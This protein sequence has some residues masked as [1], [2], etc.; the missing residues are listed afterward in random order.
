MSNLK[1]VPHKRRVMV[2]NDGVVVHRNGDGS[3]C[4]NDKYLIDPSGVFVTPHEI[5]TRYR[6]KEEKATDAETMRLL[7]KLFVESSWAMEKT[8][9]AFDKM[10]GAAREFVGL[11]LNYLEWAQDGDEDLWAA[12]WLESNYGGAPD[13]CG[14][15]YVHGVFIKEADCRIHAPQEEADDIW[16]VGATQAVRE[17]VER[18]MIESVNEVEPAF[19]IDEEKFVWKDGIC[20]GQATDEEFEYFKMLYPLKGKETKT[21]E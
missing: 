20:L 15:C 14:P 3:R 1:C 18:D 10:G 16:E 2:V 7:T 21:D 6:F 9:E 13:E 4:T 19:S 17:D 8:K 12:G 11:D 5:Q